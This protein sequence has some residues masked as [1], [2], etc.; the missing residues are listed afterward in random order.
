MHY[1]RAL[2]ARYFS[3]IPEPNYL[4]CNNLYLLKPHFLNGP[5][6]AAVTENNRAA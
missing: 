2:T 3:S 1:K 5:K 6:V 4:N